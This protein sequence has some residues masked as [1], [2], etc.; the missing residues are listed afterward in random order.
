MTIERKQK[1]LLLLKNELGLFSRAMAVL[2]DSYEQCSRIGIK[3][4]FSRNE[5]VEFDA[6]T[7]RFAPAADIFTQKILVVL[8][9]IELQD[10]GTMLDRLNRA[11][12]RGIGSSDDIL[13][14]IRDVRNDIV[15]EY[16]SEDLHAL[17][18][19]VLKLTPSLLEIEK[20]LEQY[21][22][23]YLSEI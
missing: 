23:K 14:E 15:H 6:L 5:L 7:S 11:A 22:T 2:R 9:M 12:K 10:S 4:D 1:L 3:D 17:F 21:C 19:R 13:R 8:D 18:Q 16:V 20:S